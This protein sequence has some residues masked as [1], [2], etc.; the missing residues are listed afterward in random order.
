MT[1]I[2]LLISMAIM[3][4]IATLC[5]PKNNFEKHTINSFSKQL[6]SDIRY[7]RSCNMLED[8]STYLVYVEED[9]KKGYSIKQKGEYIKYVFLPKNTVIKDNIN[10]NIIRFDNYGAPY[11]G[12]GTINISNNET[13]KEITIVPVSGRVLLKEGKYEK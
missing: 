11:P 4:L 1:L 13:K 12:G 3:L 2:E 7:V 5:F 10:N 6:C 8:T 9:G